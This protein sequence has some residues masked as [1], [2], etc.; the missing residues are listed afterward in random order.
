[1][2]QF[3]HT[4][5]R[6]GDEPRRYNPVVSLGKVDASPERG[7]ILTGLCTLEREELAKRSVQYKE[8]IVGDCGL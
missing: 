8:S 3:S 6:Y 2:H 7:Y 5:Q 4:L 1:M